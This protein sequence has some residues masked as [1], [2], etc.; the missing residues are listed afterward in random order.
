MRDKIVVLGIAPCLEEDLQNLS[1][2]IPIEEF[3][4]MAVGLDCSD[5]VLFDIQH[6]AS[7]HSEEFGAF[8]LRRAAAG[9]NLNYIAHSHRPPADCLWPLVAK[10]PLSGSSAFLGVQAAIGFGYK[11]VVLCGCP[12]QGV[13]FVGARTKKP[14]TYNRFQE[15]WK[16]FAPN[17][18]GDKCR[19]MSGWTKDFL[20]SPSKEWLNE[21]G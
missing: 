11:K 12:M 9:G 17:M 10:S 1:V 16:K 15:G 13:N 3:D 6:A 18:F 5:R 2:I 4:K 21:F 14:T 8:K 7:Y 20:G 19:S